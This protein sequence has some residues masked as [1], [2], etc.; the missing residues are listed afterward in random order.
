M[1]KTSNMSFPASSPGLTRRSRSGGLKPSLS[2]SPGH[3][4]HMRGGPVMMKTLAS[5]ERAAAI[6][7]RAEGF[8]RRDGRLHVIEVAGVLRFRRLLHF[9]QIGVVDLAAVGADRALAE[10]RV[11]GRNFLHLRDNRF[12]I[13]TLLQRRH[14]FEIMQRSGIDARLHHGGEFARRAALRL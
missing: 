2:G 9:E 13:R 3:A 8:S 11:V 12:A 1:P 6:L 5:R 4:A 10:Q 7:Q 14:S